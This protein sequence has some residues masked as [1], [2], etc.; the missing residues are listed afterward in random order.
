MAH[1]DTQHPA[2]HI[3]ALRLHA[4]TPGPAALA[5]QVEHVLSG[6]RQDFA[7][8]VQLLA[9]LRRLQAQALAAAACPPGQPA[10]RFRPPAA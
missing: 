8:A 3:F 6:E 9:A 7:D 10:A 5:G 2:T 4:K 1:P